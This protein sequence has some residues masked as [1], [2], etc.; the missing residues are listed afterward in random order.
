MSKATSARSLV[1]VLALSLVVG[2]LHAASPVKGSGTL[3][4]VV[5]EVAKRQKSVKT[6]QA[7]FRQEKE[8]ALLARP[9]VSTGTF[10]FSQP[11]NVLW[12]YDTPKPVT[13]LISKGRLT[14]YYPQLHKAETLEVSK[15][16]DRIFKYMGAG[17]AIEDLAAYFHFRFVDRKGD[18]LYRLELSPKNKAIASR[19]KGI[20]IW[21]DRQSYLTTRFEYIE[22]DGDLT[23]YEFKNIRLNAPVPAERFTLNLPSN[24]KVQQMKLN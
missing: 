18:P 12:I 21:I 20:T 17:G 16:Q 1:V 6:L 2:S 24:V 9:E 11:N 3:E 15:Y 22:A 19:V 14:T 13:M 10:T 4:H 23:R 5:K 7:E 8:M